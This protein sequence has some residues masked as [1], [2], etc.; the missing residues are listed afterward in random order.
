[1]EHG[2]L[3]PISDRFDDDESVDLEENR[4]DQVVAEYVRRCRYVL[5]AL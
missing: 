2:Q 4:D 3:E 1:M 5:L